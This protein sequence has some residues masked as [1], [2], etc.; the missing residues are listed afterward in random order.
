MYSDTSTVMLLDYGLSVLDVP[1]CGAVHT[2]RPIE[3]PPGF[4]YPWERIRNSIIGKSS[5][6][7]FDKS[8][9]WQNQQY[10]LKA[11]LFQKRRHRNWPLTDSFI[12]VTKRSDIQTQLL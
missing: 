3:Y 8:I 7:I 10:W 11:Y 5:G 9:P 12:P 1:N 4:Q 6:Q 2:L